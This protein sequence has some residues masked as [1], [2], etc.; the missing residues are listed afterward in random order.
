ML[1]GLR[2]RLAELYVSS[3]EVNSGLNTPKKEAE[4]K[5]ALALSGDFDEA[6]KARD[7][8]ARIQNGK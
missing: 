7:L 4:L 3:G 1:S 6:G 2:P 5:A 8:L